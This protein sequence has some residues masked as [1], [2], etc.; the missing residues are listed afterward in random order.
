MCL[1]IAEA[2]MDEE[3]PEFGVAN[4]RE[5]LRRLEGEFISGAHDEA[6][7][8]LAGIGLTVP[9][10]LQRRARHFADRVRCAVGG[11]VRRPLAL[12]SGDR[13]HLWRGYFARILRCHDDVET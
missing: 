5:T 7:E 3:Q 2:A 10:P 9:Q 1:A 6:C 12:N 4:F 8:A 11:G 13:R